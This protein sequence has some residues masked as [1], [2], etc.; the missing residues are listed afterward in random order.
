MKTKDQ[1]LTM[2]L[3]E[4]LK[5]I[6]QKEIENLPETLKALEPK[7]RINI[8]CKLMPYVFPKIETVHPTE[9]EPIQW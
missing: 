1:V 3:R 8:V 2:G 6:M 5:T 7:E 4:T 9:G